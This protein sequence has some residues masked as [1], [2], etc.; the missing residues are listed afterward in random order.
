MLFTSSL[1]EV[2][3]R[4]KSIIIGDFN[5]HVASDDRTLVRARQ[6]KKEEIY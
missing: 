3:M 6:I 5:A 4:D 2:A 1:A